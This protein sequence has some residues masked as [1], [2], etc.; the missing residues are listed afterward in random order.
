MDTEVTK[1]TDP[2][3]RRERYGQRSDGP[4]QLAHEVQADRQA[5]RRWPGDLCQRDLRGNVASTPTFNR[6]RYWRFD[7]LAEYKFT[8]NFSLQL[9]VVNLTDTLYYDTLYQSGIP[10]VFVAPGR[11]GYLTLNWKY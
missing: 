8:D 9:N 3:N 7:A 5:D 10:F 1:S 11:A 2:T 6:I 4:V